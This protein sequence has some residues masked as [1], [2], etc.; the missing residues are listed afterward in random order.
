[1]LRTR[2]RNTVALAALSATVVAGMPC[3]CVARA[4]QPQTTAHA[5]CP[6]GAG[7]SHAPADQGAV[8]ATHPPC[9][10]CAGGH[11]DA[12][13]ASVVS[14]HATPPFW[15]IAAALPDAAFVPGPALHR[16]ASDRQ[17]PGRSTRLFVV[18]RTLLL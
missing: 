10:H 16:L 1:M 6:H 12:I 8:A 7:G 11:I 9:A 2:W 13:A 3:L 4:F 17:P 15:T 14:L 5:C 18:L